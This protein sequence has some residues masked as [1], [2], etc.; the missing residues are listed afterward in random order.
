MLIKELVEDKSGKTPTFYLKN[1][2]LKINKKL[3]LFLENYSLKNKNVD[4]RICIHKNK[5]SKHHSMVLLQNKKNYY[6]PHK[7]KN[8][9]DTFLILKGKLACFLFDNKGNIKFKCILKRDEIFRTP[10]NTFHAIMPITKKVLYF[11]T[12]KGPFLKKNDSIFASWSPLNNEKKSKIDS[13]KNMLLK[14][15]NEI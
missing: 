1:E 7:H 6:R 3:L 8:K 9:G 12:K 15:I 13:Y 10:D 11:E 2:N 4:A 5:S 14:S